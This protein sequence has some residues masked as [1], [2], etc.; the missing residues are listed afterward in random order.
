MNLTQKKEKN[1]PKYPSQNSAPVKSNGLTR[2][3]RAVTVPMIWDKGVRQTRF[4]SRYR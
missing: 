3:Q 1:T 2:E 4:G